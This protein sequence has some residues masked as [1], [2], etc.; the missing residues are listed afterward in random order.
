MVTATVRGKAWERLTLNPTPSSPAIYLSRAVAAGQPGPVE[1][2]RIV[3]QNFNATAHRLGLA[4]GGLS[5]GR[6]A[7]HPKVE[8]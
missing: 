6:H 3:F 2:V 4:G 5:A 8:P 7:E 1:E